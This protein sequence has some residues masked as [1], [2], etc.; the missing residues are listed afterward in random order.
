[1]VAMNDVLQQIENA[2]LNPKYRF[3]TFIVG[4]NN[5]FAQSACVAVAESPG[6]TYN[7]LFLYGGAGLGKT[8]LMHSIGHYILDMLQA[9]SSQT[10]SSSRSEAVMPHLWRGFVI[11]TGLSMYSL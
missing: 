5:N 9:S 7:P 11:N 4:R 8:H 1:M 2:N 6:N 3:D 10:R